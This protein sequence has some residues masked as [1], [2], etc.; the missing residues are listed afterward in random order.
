MPVPARCPLGHKPVRLVESVFTN[1]LVSAYRALYRVDIA[2][3]FDGFDEISFCR[4]EECGL[5]FFDPATP[6]PA[7][8]YA[9]LAHFPWYYSPEKEEYRL[10]ARRVN[11]G[12]SVLEVGCGVGRFTHYLTKPRYVGLEFNEDAVRT[13]S[14]AGLDVRDES[15]EKFASS[16]ENEFDVV[17]AFQVLEHVADPSS[18][19]SACVACARPGGLV[20]FAVPNSGG[21]LGVQ[22]DNILNMPP[23]HITWWAEGVFWHV[24]AQ[25]GL[26]VIATEAERLSLSH[27]D[28]YADARIIRLLMKK[29]EMKQTFLFAG[30][31]Y[32]VMKR[33]AKMTRR[34]MLVG[35]YDTHL[36]P[37]GH[38]LLA[39]LRKVSTE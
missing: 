11:A 6:G 28:A 22:P 9:E 18:F 8:L 10:A 14:A 33:I 30:R 38:T 29:L 2:T 25:F 15:I 39:V 4:C 7:A 32:A 1:Q 19:M 5:S 23:H 13:A 12:Q 17:C 24:A 26:E 3:M 21:F 35:S 34:L 36:L 16:H 37:A 27:M 20:M 31:H